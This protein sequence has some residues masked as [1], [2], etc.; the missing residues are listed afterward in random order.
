MEFIKIHKHKRVIHQAVAT[1]AD[2][3]TCFPDQGLIQRATIIVRIKSK[4]IPVTGRGGP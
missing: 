4:A 3:E 2:V 1:G